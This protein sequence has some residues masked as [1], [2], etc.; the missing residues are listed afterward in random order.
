MVL[1]KN[2]VYK[3]VHNHISVKK[4]KRN[5]VIFSPREDIVVEKSFLENIPC[6]FVIGMDEKT[7]VNCTT[8]FEPHWCEVEK[9]SIEDYLKI[10]YCIKDTNYLYD[11]K[12]K[13]I[14]FKDGFGE[15]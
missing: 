2:K 1:E 10:P 11:M 6:L 5:Y 15:R 3:V 9:L 13:K 8:G 7:Y 14:C 12:Q 4:F